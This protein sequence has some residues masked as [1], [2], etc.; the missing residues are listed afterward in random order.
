MLSRRSTN[1]VLPDGFVQVFVIDGPYVG[2]HQVP[3]FE[4]N[5]LK[6]AGYRVKFV[7]TLVVDPLYI[8]LFAVHIDDVHKFDFTEMPNTYTLE[9]Y[10]SK[11]DPQKTIIPH[12]IWNYK[13][14]DLD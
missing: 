9:G 3:V 4:A 2:D 13:S 10:L 12:R 8:V 11:V 7:E 5:M 1:V 14:W 6:A